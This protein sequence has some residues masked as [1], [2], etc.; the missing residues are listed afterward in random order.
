MA[1]DD[2]YIAVDWGTTNRRAYLIDAGG[3]CVRE[4]EDGKG[5]LSVPKDGFHSAVGEIKAHLG[6]RPLLLAGMVGSNRGWAEAPYVPCPGGLRELA[7]GI[8]WVE[9]GAG[10]VPGMSYVGN[11]RADVMRGEEVQVLGAVAAGLIPPDCTVCHP[12]THNKWVS[13]RDGGIQ[14]FRSVMTGELFNLLKQH[15]ILSDLLSQDALEGEA[16]D[17][18]VRTGLTSDDLQS[19]LFAVRA[20]VLL[21]EA[22]RADAASYTSGLLIGSDVRIGLKEAGEGPVIVMARPELTRLYAAAIRAAG[23]GATELDGE[24]V[25]LAGMARIKELV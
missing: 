4:F 6:D 23:R 15:S 16:F 5:V 12:G 10:I 20:R 7:D 8:V 19:E 25:F 11:G 2:G 13:L 22:Q 18:G 24:R 9:E 14:H 3:E 21:G 1:W 17:A